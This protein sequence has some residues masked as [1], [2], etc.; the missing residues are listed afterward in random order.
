MKIRYKIALW[1]VSAGL[2]TSFVFSLVVFLEMR[3]QPLQILDSQLKSASEAL[4]DHMV[5]KQKIAIEELENQP[6][7]FPN[8]NFWIKIYDQ[9]LRPVYQS[10]LSRVVDLPLDREKI[11]DTYSATAKLYKN[12]NKLNKD[13]N[14]DVTFRVRVTSFKIGNTSFWVQAAMP[15]EKLMEENIDLLTALGLGMALSAGALLFISYF[16]AGYILRPVASLNRFALE[17]NEKT[18][19]QR[20]PLGKSHD[21]IFELSTCLNNMLDRL[22]YSFV[23]QKQYLADASHELKSPLAMLRLFFEEAAQS[24]ELPK[25]WREKL[26]SHLHSLLRLDRLVKNLLELTALEVGNS[27]NTESFCLTELL[28]SVSDDFAP[29]LEKADIRLEANVPQHLTM[30]GD[31]EKIQRVFINLL[32]NAIKYNVPGG[33]IKLDVTPRQG[34]INIFLSNTG[35]GI[36]RNECEKVFEQFYRVEKSR[37]TQYGG[38]GLG[39]A[40]VREIVRL[41]QGKV[42]ID[43]GPGEWT[44]VEINL[45]ISQVSPF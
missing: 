44:R 19:E 30:Q 4:S 9:A 35:P 12:S 34:S 38:A 20:I 17:V 43:S 24:P 22:E 28:Q 26:T 32:D 25:Q 11:N 42:S 21:E 37:S 8:K 7:I 27:Q 29:L 31:R 33:Q 3:E 39:L 5:K 23:K 2:L 40:I 45:P 41:H 10:E 36:P 1:V 15:V 13:E 16:F 18:L 14:D 6:V